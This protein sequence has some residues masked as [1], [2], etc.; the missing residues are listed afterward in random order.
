MDDAEDTGEKSRSNSARLDTERVKARDVQKNL[1]A[2]VPSIPGYRFATRF[3]ACHVEK[4]LNEPVHAHGRA[5][6]ALRRP[7]VTPLRL[8][9]APKRLRVKQDRVQRIAQVVCDD[10]EHLVTRPYGL[11]ESLMQ[12]GIVDS[13]R[14][15]ARQPFDQAH[16]LCAIASRSA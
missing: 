12:P 2:E 8:T 4:V 14:D 13:Q 3:E 6:N 15:Q 7:L 1:L 10:A 11:F 16:V 9:S 5:M